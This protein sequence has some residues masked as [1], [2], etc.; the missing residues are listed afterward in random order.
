M[1]D[2]IREL[3]QLSEYRD[4]I[5]SHYG[6][7]LPFNKTWKNVGV[8]V[9]GGADSALLLYMVCDIIHKNNLPITVHVITNVRCWKTRPW[10]QYDSLGVYNY[11]IKL[12]PNIK[13]NRYTNLVPPEFEWGVNGPTMIDEYGKKVSGDN[14]EL[15]SFAEYT[16]H[17]NDI[18]AYFNGVTRNPPVTIDYAMDTRNTDPSRENL[19]LMIMKHMNFL[20]CH[21]FRFLDKSVI[22]SLYKKL[23]LTGLLAITR[24][25]EGEFDNITYD[26]YTPGQY[27]PL[28]NK[29]FWC[30]ER[31]WAIEQTK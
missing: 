18:D 19:H 27:V 20:A 24:S 10:Q 12:F 17:S 28:C 13:F 21:P 26:T 31:A 5:Q 3:Y 2:K 1:L 9:S 15:R 22:M 14:I 6:L 7:S 25:C 23:D 16:C 11:M 8:A 30:N 4:I 29:C